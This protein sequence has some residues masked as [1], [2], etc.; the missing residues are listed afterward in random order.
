V[1][2]LLHFPLYSS[3]L[4]ARLAVRFPDLPFLAGN[5]KGANPEGRAFITL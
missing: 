2:V 3:W 1:T 4:E 5:K